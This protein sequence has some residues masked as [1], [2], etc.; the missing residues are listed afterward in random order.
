MAKGKY[1]LMDLTP[2]GR[3]VAVVEKTDKEHLVR[4]KG[5]FSRKE[6]MEELKKLIKKKGKK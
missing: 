4:V 3:K 2:K 1:Y 6:G 5:V